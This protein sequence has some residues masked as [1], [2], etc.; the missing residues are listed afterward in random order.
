MDVVG[1]YVSVKIIAQWM[2]VP[3][4]YKLLPMMQV[5]QVVIILII[6]VHKTEINDHLHQHLCYRLD[7]SVV[8]LYK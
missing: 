5:L 4:L 7:E 6:T 3:M 2:K 8:V 1:G